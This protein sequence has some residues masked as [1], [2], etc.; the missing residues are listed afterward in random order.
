MPDRPESADAA[1]ADAAGQG[2]QLLDPRAILTSI[3]EVVYDW[4]LD[5]DVLN[6]GSN[7]REVLKLDTIQ[8]VSTGRS[9][10][11]FLDPEAMTNRF[12][13]V[14]NSAQ[15]DHG[16]GVPYQVQY[17]ILPVGRDDARLWLEDTG[18]WFAGHDGRPLRAHGVL[19]VINARHEADQRLAYLSRFDAL[20]GQMNRPHLTEMLDQVIDNA[21]RYR[22][23]LGFLLAGIDNLGIINEAYGFEVADEVIGAVAR[24]IRSRMRAGDGL[25]RYSG[26]KFGII[27]NKCDLADMPAAAQ[28][29][30]EAVSE[31]VVP[32]Q[33]GPISA[34]IS[35][36]GVLAPRHARN[37]VEA[38]NRAQEALGQCRVARP[39][40][41]LAFAPSSAREEARRENAR[42]TDEIVSAL[43]EQR[44]V[45]AYEPI[46]DATS[47]AA[48]LCECLVRLRRADG[49]IMPAGSIVPISEKLGL[50][51]L[52]DH[53]V[54][55]LAIAEL[56][57]IRA[58]IAR[59]TCR[60]PPRR[61][62]TGF[63]PSPCACIG[64]PA[65]P[66]A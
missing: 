41:F 10:S 47:R 34:R 63:R 29:F 53:R 38:V 57:A 18:R 2:L 32:T 20:T 43:N 33:V 8:L 37:G 14:F 49:T 25:G 9:F 4:R 54:L 15:Q 64:S 24:R 61:T 28:R 48:S 46:V 11:K 42:L 27:I 16:S 50:V 40:G 56:A 44:I 65:S 60:P 5:T 21:K 19:R 51:R 6:W 35:I 17:S 13:A 3:H 55:E 45:L 36:G 58:R 66:V 31:E 22:T 39:G 30:L 7:A 23:S 52:I 12:E 59:S 26:N 62:R 1:G